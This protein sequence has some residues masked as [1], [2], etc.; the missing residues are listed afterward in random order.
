MIRTKKT[1]LTA[2][3][4]GLTWVNRHQKRATDNQYTHIIYSYSYFI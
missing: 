1:H 3:K 2:L 4:S